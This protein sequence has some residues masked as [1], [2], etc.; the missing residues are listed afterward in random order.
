MKLNK[1][2]DT[3]YNIMYGRE[4]GKSYHEFKHLIKSLKDNPSQTLLINEKYKDEVL[5]YINSF[6]F[7]DIKILIRDNLPDSIKAAIIDEKF[8][9]Q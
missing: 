6:E 3:L 7:I 9:R 5:S 2:E 8:W 4:S 1:S